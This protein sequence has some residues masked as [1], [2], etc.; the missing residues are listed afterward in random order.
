MTNP[1]TDSM[2][3][4]S[5]DVADSDDCKDITGENLGEGTYSTVVKCP[6]RNVA[7][8]KFKITDDLQAIQEI[9][10]L[11]Y[12]DSPWIISA[13]SIN[14]GPDGIWKIYMKCYKTDLSGNW[15]GLIHRNPL[16]ALCKLAF[17]IVAGVDYMHKS[18]VLHC[19]IKPKNILIDTDTCSAAICDFNIS[20]FNPS[21]VLSTL[22]QTP[23][24]RAP[25]V[26]FTRKNGQ[27]GFK[28]DIWSLG[29]T[30]FYMLTG[31]SFSRII[32]DDSSLCACKAYNLPT[33]DS[34][35]Q[36]YRVLR[37]MNRQQSW[38][39]ILKRIKS[40]QW[41]ELNKMS[42][43]D[44]K[45]KDE[46]LKLYLTLLS[47]CLLPNYTSRCDSE[48]AFNIA[49]MLLKFYDSTTDIE[50]LEA[51]KLRVPLSSTFGAQSVIKEDLDSVSQ[52]ITLFTH[53][54]KKI[55]N[56]GKRIAWQIKILGY[57]GTKLTQWIQLL[58][59]KYYNKIGRKKING[60]REASIVT[61]SCIFLT[62]C[63]TENSTVK[64]K[65]PAELSMKE[66]HEKAIEVM[67]TLHYEIIV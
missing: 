66:I 52:P 63:I 50:T 13:K 60:S 20:I 61:A 26:N 46:F 22:V 42:H 21:S 56:A 41:M 2:K 14:I 36:R 27:F 64:E 4:S 53:D 11:K 65:Y 30:L 34:R 48:K 33:Y 23:G 55:T 40:T 3:R 38:N 49:K 5:S 8:K 17:D 45:Y 67:K 24:Y 32:T 57:L 44:D 7:V 37:D 51:S 1:P 62:E 47:N 6:M 28:I 19:D 54:M 18:K 25:E 12:L 31:K 15:R 43:I 10:I 9:A 39:M 16:S 59:S 58:E 35:A 29:A